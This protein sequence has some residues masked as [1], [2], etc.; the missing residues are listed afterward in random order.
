MH[1]VTHGSLEEAEN[2][3]SEYSIEVIDSDGRGKFVCFIP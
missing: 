2:I 3:F 1:G